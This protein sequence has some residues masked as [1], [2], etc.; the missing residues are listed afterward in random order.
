MSLSSLNFSI[1]IFG[2]FRT[3]LARFVRKSYHTGS[4]SMNNGLLA[5]KQKEHSQDLNVEFLE[6][7]KE[8]KKRL[9]R[10][11]EI[12]ADVGVCLKSQRAC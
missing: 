6:L 3:N 7:A 9:H 8:E 5:S 10:K 2:H 4:T 12:R 11:K 1:L